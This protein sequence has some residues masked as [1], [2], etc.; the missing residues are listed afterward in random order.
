MSNPSNYLIRLIHLLYLY[1]L[2]YPGVTQE[3]VQH[4][5]FPFL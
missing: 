3:V 2:I 4:H 1:L 5:T